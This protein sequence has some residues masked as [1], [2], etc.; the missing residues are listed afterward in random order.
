MSP[1]AKWGLDS[2]IVRQMSMQGDQFPAHKITYSEMSNERPRD[3][4]GNRRV[5][6]GQE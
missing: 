3:F 1:A 6:P 4:L 2:R 5:S